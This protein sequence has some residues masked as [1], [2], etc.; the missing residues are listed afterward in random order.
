MPR[1]LD[2]A[3]TKV[4][5]KAIPRKKKIV[6]KKVK[7]KVTAK[8]RLVMEDGDPDGGKKRGKNI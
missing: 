3:K 5:D 1:D 8:R 7:S 6:M 2:T 4:A